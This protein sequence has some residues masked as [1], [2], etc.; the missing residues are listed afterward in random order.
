MSLEDGRELM[1]KYCPFFEE[2]DMDFADLKFKN[3]ADALSLVSFMDAFIPLAQDVGI[4]INDVGSGDGSPRFEHPLY[5]VYFSV[6]P[7][8][9]NYGQVFQKPEAAPINMALCNFLRNYPD[10][11]EKEF[12]L[13]LDKSGSKTAKAL[14][15][16]NDYNFV[17]IQ[18]SDDKIN[19]D[20]FEFMGGFHFK[21]KG[22]FVTKWHPFNSSDF[23]AYKIPEY[24]KELQKRGYITKGAFFSE[25]DMPRKQEENREK[26]IL[27]TQDYDVIT[28]EAEDCY[29]L[30]NR[31][32]TGVGQK[33][34]FAS[35]VCEVYGV[36][37][38]TYQP[39]NDEHFHS[40]FGKRAGLLAFT[41]KLERHELEPLESGFKDEN[42][43]IKRVKI[44]IKTILASRL[45]SFKTS[46][47]IERLKDFPA[48][49]ANIELA[50]L[51]DILESMEFET[52]NSESYQR[53]QTR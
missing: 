5:L 11:T 46:L 37:P 36:G 29:N 51:L 8:R 41:N 28:F 15:Y 21:Q 7:E 32:R 20:F 42:E 45:T 4:K 25:L 17:V 3:F 35:S 38:M 47:K 48:K 10:F 30:V 14:S 2:S 53:R 13:I 44:A 16:L 52:H 31:S 22:Y 1:K 39:Q 49:I 33:I 6:K 19:E 40:Y 50:E 43:E 18:S 34:G 26:L 12:Y 23:F 9:T 27:Q 24:Q